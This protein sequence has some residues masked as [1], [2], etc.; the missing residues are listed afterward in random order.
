MSWPA[1]AWAHA[2]KVGSSSEKAVLLALAYRHNE[3]LDMAYPSVSSIAQFTELDRKTI[4]AAIEKLTQ[5]GLV[6]DSGERMGK[7]KQIIAYTL[8]KLEEYRKRNSSDFS[9]ERVPE[10][11]QGNSKGKERTASEAKAS[12]AGRRYAFSGRVIKLDAADLES[13]RSAYHAIPDIVAELTSIDAW[14]Q[15]QPQDQRKRWFHSV[16]GMLGRKHQ[17][18]LKP[19][20]QDDIYAY[21]REPLRV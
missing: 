10:T 11:V 19:T 21:R 15:G 20:K 4:F 7:T 3:D 5:K 13:W 12:S 18:M 1:L 17:E 6:A 9:G 16:P 14:L 8:P 2:L